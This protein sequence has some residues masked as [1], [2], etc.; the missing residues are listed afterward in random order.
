MLEYVFN[1]SAT[2]TNCHPDCNQ[3]IPE[4]EEEVRQYKEKVKHLEELVYM[5][6]P[7]EKRHL[8]QIEEGSKTTLP[9][10]KSPQPKTFEVKD[11]EINL[12]QIKV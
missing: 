5:L 11:T 10:L 1:L 12:D 2:R 6:L 8:I 4:L 9:A 7:E 3:K